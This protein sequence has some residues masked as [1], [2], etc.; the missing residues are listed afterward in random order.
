MISKE[1]KLNIGTH[2]KKGKLKLSSWEEWR[3][4]EETEVAAQEQREGFNTCSR[5]EDKASRHNM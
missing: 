2:I 3:G 4:D 1:Q 5:M